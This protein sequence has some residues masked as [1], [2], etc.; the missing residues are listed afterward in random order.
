MTR[1]PTLH[2]PATR[3]TTVSAQKEHRVVHGIAC[4]HCA[5][6]EKAASVKDGNKQRRH[7][8]YWHAA[9]GTGRQPHRRVRLPRPVLGEH[10]SAELAK[11]PNC[12]AGLRNTACPGQ[13]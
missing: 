3:V 9:Q 4:G 10:L 2:L 6:T 11:A 1:A 12:K 5:E 13:S 7:G 8:S